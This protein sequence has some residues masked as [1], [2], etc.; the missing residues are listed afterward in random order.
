MEEPKSTGN[1]PHAPGK[2]KILIVE[3]ETLLSW[4][5]TRRLQEAGYT[6][7]TVDSGDKAMAEIGSKEFDL[8]ITDMKLPHLDGLC[9]IS[10]IKRRLPTLPVIMIS[11]LPDDEMQ[12]H[13]EKLHVDHFIEK[14]FDLD[15]MVSLVSDLIKRPVDAPPRRSG[16]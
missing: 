7:T 3:D 6:V 12:T 1:K 8:V 5:L 2:V 11:A 15:E 9:I 13:L 16:I 4:S 14:P 10:E